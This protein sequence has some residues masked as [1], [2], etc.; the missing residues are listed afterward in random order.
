MSDDYLSDEVVLEHRGWDIECLSPFEISLKDDPQSRAT[1]YAARAIVDILRE[2]IADCAPWVIQSLNNDGFLSY[3]I[4]DGWV[5]KPMDAK[6]F[7]KEEADLFIEGA[8]SARATYSAQQLKGI[9]PPPF[10]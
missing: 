10:S 9:F 2:D 7:T 4:K 1:G 8:T 3:Y 5:K 6:F